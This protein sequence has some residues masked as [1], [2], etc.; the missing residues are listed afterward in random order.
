[1]VKR[2]IYTTENCIGCNK[3]VR[4]CTSFGASATT[5]GLGHL[6]ISI[7]HERC[8]LCGACIDVCSHNAR[9]YHDDTG[10]FLAD[11]IRG[12]EISVLVAPSFEAMYPE[13]WGRALA[14]LR[15]LGVAHVYPVAYGA[16]ICTWAYLRLICEENLRSMISTTCPVVVAYVERWHP[17][18][19]GKLMPVKS[20]M[21]CLAT[22]L[23]E[24]MGAT[25]RFAFI[26]P[27]IGKSF[28]TGE[29]SEV[30]YNVTFPHL[31]DALAGRLIPE[32]AAS[33][34]DVYD[35]L[36]YGL[37]A[38][39]PAAGG[40]AN[41]IR[42][43]LGDDAAVRVVSGKRY[44]YDYFEESGY[45]VLDEDVPYSLVDV[46]NCQ[47][48]CLEG[49]AR[50]REGRHDLGLT[51]I[52]EIRARAKSKEP[53]SPFNSSIP[54]FKRYEY[55]MER[56][57]DLDLDSYR[58]SFENR[59][60]DCAISIPTVEQAE[61]L[62]NSLYK[63]D[64]AS[65]AINCSACG[66]E[67]CDEMLIAIHNGFNTR[68]NCV[69]FEKE[70]AII[71]ARMSFSDQLTG[72]L[73]RNALEHEKGRMVAT[74]GPLAYIVCDTNGLKQVNDTLGHAAGDALIRTCAE[75]LANEFRRERVYRT[76]GDEFLVLIEDFARDEVERGIERVRENLFIEGASCAIGLAYTDAFD[77]DLSALERVADARMYVDKEAHYART[78]TKRR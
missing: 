76:G 56:F 55:L 60:A 63:T 23:R 30:A 38:Y 64:A 21:Q 32:E 42:W 57:K 74:G 71:L 43:F 14:T 66:Y 59:S 4:A 61:A 5:D 70:E 54:P 49:T 47:E 35:G 31:V 50:G 16:D 6:K 62:W 65:R 41:N 75:A 17:D 22:Y 9:R 72:V 53:A 69:F 28:E 73:N 12:E 29:G 44:L 67:N 11:L 52:R 2:I 36:S 7:N 19:I 18:L 48:G 24:Q 40:L 13:L 8:I 46:L 15:K 68:K 39:Y 58:R 77:G 27:C 45:L 26:G 3:C 33:E 10:A 37:G 1:M 34:V 25:G 20:P 51:R 78:G